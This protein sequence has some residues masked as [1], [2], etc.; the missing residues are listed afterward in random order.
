MKFLLLI[1]ILSFNTLS[2]T[3][4]EKVRIPYNYI[5]SKDL[6][7]NNCNHKYLFEIKEKNKVDVND[8]WAENF[9]YLPK[10]QEKRNIFIGKNNK[11]LGEKTKI[12]EWEEI[13][14]Y[15][16]FILSKKLEENSCNYIWED[17]MSEFR[18]KNPHIKNPNVLEIGDIIQVQKCKKEVL[19]DSF[20]VERKWRSH[21]PWVIYLG[22]Y[23]KNSSDW[24]LMG[25]LHFRTSLNELINYELNIIGMKDLFL[26]NQFG[27]NLFKEN[28]NNFSL[29]A[30]FA[31]N[32][33]E[34]NFSYFLFKY[35]KEFSYDWLISL[36]FASNFKSGEYIN[37]EIEYK[38]LFLFHRYFKDSNIL[39]D[40]VSNHY[41][42]LGLGFSFK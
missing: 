39:N 16:G 33:N 30:V 27:I 17:Q 9:L 5:L 29:G 34:K 8:L 42:L 26:F 40:G 13:K 22:Q 41:N 3:E 32:I 2:A 4:W 21:R 19:M 23:N 11:V 1:L 18:N 20:F 7:V 15:K 31:N 6:E 25:G 35:Q 38:N 10:C 24:E 14:V 28:R 37:T 36:S 12:H